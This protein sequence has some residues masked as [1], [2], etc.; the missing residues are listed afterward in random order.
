MRFGT[1]RNQNHSA[2]RARRSEPP[3]L[4]PQWREMR[5]W[6]SSGG[7]EAFLHPDRRANVHQMWFTA[8]KAKAKAKASGGACSRRSVTARA[9]HQ[10]GSS[11]ASR[12]LQPYARLWLHRHMWNKDFWR[13]KNK[14]CYHLFKS[15]QIYKTT[16]EP[17]KILSFLPHSLPQ[18][19][20]SRYVCHVVDGIC[21]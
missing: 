20:M 2:S 11:S 17:Q 5:L 10:G 9:A 4:N 18:K 1:D 13:S 16:N 19:L 7:R 6:Q 8:Q 15:K 3:G 21:C 14:S 12:G